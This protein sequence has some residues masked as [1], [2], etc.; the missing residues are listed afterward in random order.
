VPGLRGLLGGE[1]GAHAQ[2]LAARTLARISGP[3]AI[4]ALMTFVRN[5]D[6]RLRYLGLR[7]LARMR[8]LTGQPVLAR[9]GTHRLFLRELHDYFHAEAS[10]LALEKNAAPEVR[11]LGESYRESAEM[12][13]E[14]ALQALACWY[15]PKPLPGVF[16]RL[17]SPSREAAS[18]A[19]EYLA[20]VLPRGVFRPVQRI[21]EASGVSKPD[22]ATGDDDL[23]RRIRQAWES[24]DE[25]LRACAVH[26]SRD[27]AGFDSLLFSSGDEGSA[28]V[29]AELAALAGGSHA[30]RTAA[31]EGPPC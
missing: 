16:E 10:A 27:I 3:R 5:R 19:L 20:H 12:A 8:V 29:R 24:G 15:E 18:P 6:V 25:W 17:R 11:L 31:T 21:F 22:A 13:L 26:A 4:E 9:S 23:A 14:R 7:G 28:L 30:S 1:T 2:E